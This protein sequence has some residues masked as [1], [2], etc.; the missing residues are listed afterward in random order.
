MIVESVQCV[1][2]VNNLDIT[3]AFFSNN[4]ASSRSSLDIMVNFM[5]QCRGINKYDVEYFMEDIDKYG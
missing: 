2:K 1:V 5:L 4:L 3:S